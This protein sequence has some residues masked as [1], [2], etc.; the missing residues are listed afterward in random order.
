MFHGLA[1]AVKSVLQIRLLSIQTL[2][3]HGHASTVALEIAEVD[4][5]WEGTR[6]PQRQ[7]VVQVDELVAVYTAHI[8]SLVLLA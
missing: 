5:D 2:A 6:K 3:S 7:F 4:E 8:S 1:N